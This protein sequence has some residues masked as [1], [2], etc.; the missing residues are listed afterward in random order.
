[1]NPF[2]EEFVQHGRK[3]AEDRGASWEIP[4]NSD[5]IAQDSIGWNITSLAGAT[6]PPN[7][8]LRDF[9]PEIKAL[10]LLNQ[11]RAKDNITLL[12]STVLSN[13]WQNLLKASVSNQLFYRKNTPNHI[14][15]NIIRPLKVIATCAVGRDPW[16]LSLDDVALA[17]K[18]GT[19]MQASGKL[20]DLIKGVVKTVIDVEH[21]ADAC[22]LYPTL[23]ADRLIPIARRARH[24]KSMDE[25]RD[26][27]E[28]RKRSER[29]P[30]RR[31][32]WELVRIVFTEPPKSFVDELRFT[33]M[34]VLL[35]CGLRVGEAALLPADW[36][37]TREYFDYSGR[38]AGEFGGFS[39]A[40]MLRHFAEK[41]QVANSDSSILVEST[42]FVPEIFADLLTEALERAVSITE[43]LRKT[44]RLQMET[45]RLLPWY[46]KNDLV[47][48]IELYP[49][50]TGNP[51]WLTVDE[52][53][54]DSV[55]NSYRKDFSPT[56]L[57]DLE[58]SQSEQY[59]KGVGITL[60]VALYVYLNRLRKK[61]KSG[62]CAMRFYRSDGTPIPLEDYMYWGQVCLKIGELEDYIRSDTPTKLSD[63]QSIKIAEGEI[64]PWEFMFLTPKRSLSEER[65][66]GI[67]DITRYCSVGIPDP[68]F[69]V[70]SLGENGLHDSIFDRY[71]TNEE[72][73]KLSL[74]SH[75]LRHLQNTELFR[76]GVAD[77][78]ITKRYNRRSVAQSY[79]YDHRSL[80]EELDQIELPPDIE[81]VLGEKASIAAKMI[82]AGKATG[83][84]VDAFRRIQRLEGDDAAFQYL[85]GEADGFHATPFGHCLNSFTVDPCPKNLECFAGCR[86]LTAT[87]LSSNRKYLLKLEE[88]LSAALETAQ[89]RTSR[90]IGRDNQIKHAQVRLDAVRALLATP[91]GQQ[92]FP[93]GPDFSK[94]TKTRSV[95][96]D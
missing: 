95:L 67:C 58:L 92:V 10:E 87:N 36:K 42:Q 27:L 66:A 65:N 18:I 81:I 31:A 50:L 84:V 77:T 85:K 53:T 76:L 1:M 9:G 68:T 32:F 4:Q 93:D 39:S 29:L 17:V 75:S 96:D 37:R 47:S 55:L 78:I 43:P 33:A 13:A 45:G 26:D 91:D 34:K 48:V 40:L 86:H 25:L 23:S 82:Q 94:L 14:A 19:K 51:F 62:K 44:L 52:N 63:T 15:N 41:Q 54:I 3:M 24:T 59:K 69:L 49:Q 28:Q 38:P 72:D 6:P 30:E 74:I 7:Y 83:P 2:Y 8:Y 56:V 11:E 80:A 61:M 16:E 21:I 60:N 64:Q 79:E 22:P 89:A 35:T 20:G 12:P 71:G 90:S 5:G 70:L 88:R 57:Y 46:E 73:R